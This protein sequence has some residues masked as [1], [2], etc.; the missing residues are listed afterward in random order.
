ML[1][2]P[3]SPRSGQSYAAPNGQIYVYDGVKWLGTS[4]TGGGGGG[5]TTVTNNIENPFTFSVAADDS[6]QKEISNGELIK[7]IGAGTV[8]T[9]SDAEGNITI[10]GSGGGVT[11]SS[12]DI[13]TNKTINIAVGQGNT[14]QIQGNSISSYTG[15]GPIVVLSSMPTLS[16]FN[17]GN[18]SNL[19]V[20][21]GTGPYYWAG[22]SGVAVAGIDKAGVYRTSS[23]A[24]NSLFTFGANGSGTMSAAVEGSLFIG[25]GMPSNNGGLNT[26]YPGWLVVQS[27]GK[28]GGDVNTLGKFI[29]DSAANGAIIFGDGTTQTT[30]YT[31]PQTSLD[32]DVT[33][34]V[35]ADDSTLL[36]DGISGV[37]PNSELA[38]SITQ[39]IDSDVTVNTSATVTTNNSYTNTVDFS[40]DVDP[41]VGYAIAGWYQRNSTQ[42]EFALFGPSAF[43]T[44]LIGLALGRTVIVTYSTGGGNQTLTRTLT[45]AFAAT[46]QSDPANPT[47][48][49]VSGRIDATLPADQTGIVSINF[50]V[51][52][53][54]SKTW[55]FDTY[56]ALT[57]PGGNIITTASGF[58]LA[59][60][61][62]SVLTL[63]TASYEWQFNDANGKLFLPIKD[64]ADTGDLELRGGGIY[65]IVDEDLIIGARDADD[66]G[67]SVYLQVDDGAGS[68][69]SETRLRR[70]RFVVNIDKGGANHN[71]TFDDSGWFELAGDIRAAYGVNTSIY[72][73]GSSDSNI[74]R[75]QTVDNTDTVRSYV[76]VKNRQIAL[77]SGGNVWTFSDTGSIIFPDATVQTTAYN[78]NSIRS[79]GDINIDINLSDS[80]LRRWTFGEDGD[81]NIPG[82]IRFPNG[83]TIE[84]SDSSVSPVFNNFTVKTKNGLGETRTMDFNGTRISTNSDFA[85]L[86]NQNS[87]GIGVESTLIRIGD[88][89]GT[90]YLDTKFGVNTRTGNQGDVQF[91]TPVTGSGSSITVSPNNSHHWNFGSQGLL[92]LGSTLGGIHANQTTGRITIGDSL[93]PTGTLSAPSTGI[94]IGGPDYVFSIS[95]YAELNAPVWTFGNDRSL[96]IPGNITSSGNIDIEINLTDSTRRR[97]SFGEDGNLETPGDITAAGNIT[98]N[99]LKIEDGVHEKFQPLADAT[100]T[101]VHDCSLGHIF[102]H[103]SPDTNWTANFTNLN[104]AAGYATTVSIVIVQGGTGYYPNA[105]QIG[106]SAQT[107]NWQ[108]NTTPTVSTNRTDVASFSIINNS[109]TYVVLGQITGF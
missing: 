85:S 11:A 8:T 86:Y 16:G 22:Q 79:E 51:Y 91:L 29:L 1:S 65:Q 84:N 41:G 75:L 7:F 67:F 12:S 61:N 96:N 78:P 98:G 4:V 63:G 104:L 54:S 36:V 103:T 69:L 13:F 9:A 108:G 14:F 43:Q 37:V 87:F 101:V 53:T 55:T 66:D 59:P 93:G 28:F 90:S 76:E 33:G 19:T 42:I 47:W 52:S 106:G 18:S 102:Y 77:M 105:V 57:L 26:D 58:K 20:D 30:A 109:G 3:S 97:W 46:G 34:S 35:F 6:S 21:G 95:K 17:I 25:T 72:L 60:A 82:I 99:I 100:G 2:F 5:T 68:V 81:F 44:Y 49:R 39:V 89:G 62:G 83:V 15:S 92:S 80:T 23:S 56:G 10:T 38:K 40:T 64:S 73:P 31:G 71:W 94:M 45:Q 74:L 88:L 32:G 70:D 50:P 27:G 107:I 24:T 48:G